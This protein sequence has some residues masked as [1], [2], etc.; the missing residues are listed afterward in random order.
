MAQNEWRSLSHFCSVLSGAHGRQRVAT[1]QTLLGTDG[2]YTEC[3]WEG[4]QEGPLLML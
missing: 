4:G 1:V 3:S 2:N